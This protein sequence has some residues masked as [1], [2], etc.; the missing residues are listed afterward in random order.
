MAGG[1]NVEVKEALAIKELIL[2]KLSLTSAIETA[3][4]TQTITISA[5]GPA[6]VGTATISKWLTVVGSD[7]V[8]YYIPMWT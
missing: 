4:A 1:K 2:S 3:N 8:T 6:G 5:L 7:G